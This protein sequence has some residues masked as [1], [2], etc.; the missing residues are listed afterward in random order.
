MTESPCNGCA[1]RNAVCHSVC[2]RYTE[3]CN[4]HQDEIAAEKAKRSVYRALN[5][6]EIS[7]ARENYVRKWKNK[8][9]KSE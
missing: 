4:L 5:G 7:K 3:W 2:V 9:K 1:E 6:Y 8:R